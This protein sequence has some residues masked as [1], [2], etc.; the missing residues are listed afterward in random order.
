MPKMIGQGLSRRERE[1]CEILHRLREATAAEILE[2]LA[3]PPS[4][5]AVRSILRILEEKGHIGHVENGKRYVYSTVEAPQSA[6]QFALRQLART[7][8]DG[9][10][11]QVVKTFLSDSDTQVS[12][13]ELDRLSLIIDDARN[14]ENQ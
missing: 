9:S 3:D 6:A 7:F 4:Y 5:S 8:F 1:I 11:E 2:A 14:K 12:E 10:L 13:A